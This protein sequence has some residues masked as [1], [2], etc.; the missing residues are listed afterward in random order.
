MTYTEKIIN[1]ATG[2]ETIREF[3]KEEIARFEAE[4]AEFLAIENAK[5]QEEAAKNAARQVVLDKLGLTAEEAA[6]L[7]A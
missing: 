6:A 1:I 3:T 2:E 5:R 7:L 4:K